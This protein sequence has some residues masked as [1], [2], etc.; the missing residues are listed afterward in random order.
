[1]FRLIN[2]FPLLPKQTI[3]VIFIIPPL[4]HTPDNPLECPLPLSLFII[5]EAFNGSM[6]RQLKL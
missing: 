2:P 4:S 1:M 5:M 3:Q 6:N